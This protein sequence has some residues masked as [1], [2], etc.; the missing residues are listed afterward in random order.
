MTEPKLPRSN[1]R[2]YEMDGRKF[3]RVSTFLSSINKPALVPWA[4]KLEREACIEAARQIYLAPPDGLDAKNYAER[5]QAL[6]GEAKAHQKVMQDAQDIGTQAHRRMEW[7]VRG[8]IGAEPPC[9]PPALQASD[10]G[11][12]W[13]AEVDFKL[14]YA[15]Q[16]VWSD[17]HGYAGTMDIHGEATLPGYGRCTIIGDYK[18]SSGVYPEM[19]LQLAAYWAALIEM[20]HASS[21]LHAVILR[22]P[23]K[24][25]DPGF[26]AVVLHDAELRAMVPVFLA[27]GKLWAYL[28][29]Q[30]QAWRNKRKAA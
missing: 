17:I 4:A 29:E 24:P 16:T 20:G 13:L 26:E 1:S 6:I 5:F 9:S 19:K 14:K 30:D 12:K 28:D 3:W 18:T 2:W 15:E 7:H 23:K 21:P 22:L 10:A 8:R 27:A 25:S 11:I